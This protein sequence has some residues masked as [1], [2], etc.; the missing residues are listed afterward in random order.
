MFFTHW[1][2]LVRSAPVGQKANEAMQVNSK[3]APSPTKETKP[4]PGKQI[5][6]N[7]ITPQTSKQEPLREPYGLAIVAKLLAAL[8]SETSK[9]V[10]DMFASLNINILLMPGNNVR[11]CPLSLNT[12]LFV[13]FGY[14]FAKLRQ[15]IAKH[16]QHK[17]FCEGF[18]FF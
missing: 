13:N 18:G 7:Q 4:K 10:F 17:R 6:K 5:T 11:N 14:P 1:P 8:S 2:P 15:V 12:C 16:A 3:A 9:H